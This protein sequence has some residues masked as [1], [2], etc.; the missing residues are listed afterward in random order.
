MVAA[1][2][3]SGSFELTFLK[4]TAHNY[5]DAGMHY[6]DRNNYLHS[7]LYIL[8]AKYTCPHI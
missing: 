1:F 2:F 7:Y 4:L 6:Y 3:V 5:T 8:T